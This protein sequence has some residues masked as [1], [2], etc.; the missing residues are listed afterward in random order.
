MMAIRYRHQSNIYE[1]RTKVKKKE[2]CNILGKVRSLIYWTKQLPQN[3]TLNYLIDA[4]KMQVQSSMRLEIRNGPMS[5]FN[6]NK[7]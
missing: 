5:R 2:D 1:G 7:S 4:S 3:L 6:F